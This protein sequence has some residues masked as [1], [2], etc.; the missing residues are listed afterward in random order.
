MVDRAAAQDDDAARGIEHCDIDGD[1]HLVECRVVLGIEEAR[2]RRGKVDC[3]PIAMQ[4]SRAE[5]E[6]A[7]SRELRGVLGAVVSR[8]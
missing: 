8:Q 2:V 5:I 4:S 1:F 7:V 3:A 6:D